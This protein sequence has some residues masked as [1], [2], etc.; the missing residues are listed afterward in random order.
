MVKKLQLIQN[1][2]ARV[3]VRQRLCEHITPVLAELHWLPVSLRI[4]FKIL[5]TIFKVIHH[6]E[7]APRYLTELLK[8]KPIRR[9]TRKGV[10]PCQLELFRMRRLKDMTLKTYGDRAFAVFGPVI[11]NAL[12]P[13]MR[14]ITEYDRF[15]SLLKA[16]LY[17]SHYGV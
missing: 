9:V 14:I 4:N 13:E 2:A 6:S 15:K 12:P 17:R 5:C 8:V 1:S 10:E 16:H 11:W 7:T 3:V